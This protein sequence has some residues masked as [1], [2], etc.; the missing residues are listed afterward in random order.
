MVEVEGHLADGRTVVVLQGTGRTAD[1][2][3]THT[4]RP[5]GLGRRGRV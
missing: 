2:V 5:V 1:E 3:A 4:A